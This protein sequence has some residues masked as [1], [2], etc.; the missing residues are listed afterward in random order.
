MSTFV[1]TSDAVAPAVFARK[2]ILPRSICAPKMFGSAVS[3]ILFTMRA[4]PPV[5]SAAVGAAGVV[6][7][8][9]QLLAGATPTIE[10]ASAGDHVT[11]MLQTSTW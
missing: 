4:R 6:N 8:E 9:V 3:A 7:E 1:S 2:E 10:S 11:R 5:P